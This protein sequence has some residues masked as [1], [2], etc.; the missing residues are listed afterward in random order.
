[1]V[2][3]E[4]SDPSVITVLLDLLGTA[5]GSRDVVGE[6]SGSVLGLWRRTRRTG[7]PA[8]TVSPCDHR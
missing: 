1:V 4:Q 7:T 8:N 6:L 2:L 5:A 3:T